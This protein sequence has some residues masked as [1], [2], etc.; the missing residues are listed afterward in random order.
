MGVHTTGL[1]LLNFA[2]SCTCIGEMNALTS[3]NASRLYQVLA[4]YIVEV[5][6]PTKG[7][8]AGLPL[9]PGVAFNTLRTFMRMC[10]THMKEK[11]TMSQ[12]A[13]I[14]FYC[15]DPGS[16][17]EHRAW[18]ES[19]QHKIMYT[20]YA[21]HVKLGI[22]CVSLLLLRVLAS[23]THAYLLALQPLQPL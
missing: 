17:S 15:L 5:Y 2:I 4:T 8:S 21:Q 1:A 23:L 10:E 12:D 20:L 11:K 19:L 16:K 9:L 7:K 22:S 3:W 13:V 6:T 14:F 18:L